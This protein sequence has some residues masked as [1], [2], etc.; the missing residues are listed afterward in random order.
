MARHGGDCVLFD[1]LLIQRRYSELIEFIN[2]TVKTK[3]VQVSESEGVYLFRMRTSGRLPVALLRTFR[4][5]ALITGG[6]MSV[7]VA[8]IPYVHLFSSCEVISLIV[9]TA[10]VVAFAVCLWLYWRVMQ[11]TLYG[12]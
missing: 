3:A 2:S 11:T 7:S 6:L 5:S 8:V 4:A 12:E 10:G 1:A 9:A